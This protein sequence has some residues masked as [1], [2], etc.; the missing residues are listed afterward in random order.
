MHPTDRAEGSTNLSNSTENSSTVAANIE[1]YLSNHTK[2]GGHAFQMNMAA[3]QE[4]WH[5]LEDEKKPVSGPKPLP[6][7]AETP[8][9]EPPIG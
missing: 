7:G 6:K 1:R 4:A 9:T 5:P 3:R 8:Q 2:E